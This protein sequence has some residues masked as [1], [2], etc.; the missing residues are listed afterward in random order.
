MIARKRINVENSYVALPELVENL[1]RRL[2]FEQ[3][4]QKVERAGKELT[5]QQKEELK[6]VTKMKADILTKYVFPS[7]ANIVVFLEY[8]AKNPL[9]RDVFDN[10]MEDLL[11]GLPEDLYDKKLDDYT[12]MTM[13]PLL[14]DFLPLYF[15]GTLEKTH[16]TGD[17]YCL[18]YCNVP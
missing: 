13:K 14:Q 9:L 18:E 8:C 12:G 6:L 1:E 16:E 5:P 17:S 7:M 11:L 4:Y 2:L 3:E 15:H 10:D